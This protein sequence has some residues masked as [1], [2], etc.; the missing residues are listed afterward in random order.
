M[1][2]LV[3]EQGIAK[4]QRAQ[5]A[6]EREWHHFI[7]NEVWDYKTVVS[8][9][10]VGA[11]A[12]TIGKRTLLGR[13]CGLMVERGVELPGDDNRKSFKYRVGFQGDSVVIENWVV[14]IFQDLVSAPTSMEV[15]KMDDAIPCQFGCYQQQVDAEEAWPTDWR[16]PGGTTL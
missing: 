16:N 5:D 13:I 10:E 3:G 9:K 2:R 7:T 12:R 14:V 15:G 1:A 11:R 4:N 8:W 6:M